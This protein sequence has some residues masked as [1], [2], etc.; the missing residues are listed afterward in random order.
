M[1]CPVEHVNLFLEKN[2]YLGS[3]N[4][5]FAWSDEFGVMVWAN[6]T[7]RRLPQ[8]RWL[9]LVRWCLVGTKNGGSQQ[10][11]SFR[12]WLIVACPEV[13][14]CVSYSDPSQ[15]HTGAVYKAC[16]W[17]WAP[18]WHRLRPPPSGNGNWGSGPQS[19]KDRWIF[20]VR[21]DDERN[22][23]IRIKDESIVRS[24]AL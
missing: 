19:V 14:T 8:K 13:T 18:T 23:I 6:P 9:E 24:L 16:N 21:E 12:R 7:S 11:A 22:E 3:I 1:L 20:R 4:R 10:W 17:E 5:G 2:H 15:G